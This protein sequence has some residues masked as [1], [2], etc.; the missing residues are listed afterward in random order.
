MEIGRKM[1]DE[2]L[3][4]FQKLVEFGLWDAVLDTIKIAIN[5]VS[6]S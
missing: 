1:N 6:Q 5:E 4:Q 2:E 3:Q